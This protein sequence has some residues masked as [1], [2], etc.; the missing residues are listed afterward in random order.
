M[1]GQVP[2]FYVKVINVTGLNAL[3]VPLLLV[4]MSEFFTVL[5][6]YY[7]VKNRLIYKL[8]LVALFNSRWCNTFSSEDLGLV[9]CCED[10]SAL[11]LRVIRG[12]FDPE[13]EG[14]M[15]LRNVSKRLPVDMT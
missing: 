14:S 13:D 5:M 2:L 7:C 12:L 1:Y 3:F 8:I 10:C 6:I 4:L 9:G 11:L 15:I